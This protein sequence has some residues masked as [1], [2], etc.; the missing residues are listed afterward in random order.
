MRKS[1]FGEAQIVG[2]IK[3]Q[4]TGMLAG[5]DWLPECSSA[6]PAERTFRERMSSG[7]SSQER[8]GEI[9][10]IGLRDHKLRRANFRE[11]LSR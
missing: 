1:R 6:G 10:M 3:E 11:F 8:C 5:S 4:G 2:V 9:R 7:V